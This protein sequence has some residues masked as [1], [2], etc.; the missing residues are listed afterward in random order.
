VTFL[1]IMQIP[2]ILP[3]LAV[4]AENQG[5]ELERSQTEVGMVPAGA[6]IV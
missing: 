4:H 3:G 2:G 6:M 5:K 1:M